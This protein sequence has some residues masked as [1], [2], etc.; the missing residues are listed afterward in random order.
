MEVQFPLVT[1]ENFLEYGRKMAR[2]IAR[3]INREVNHEPVNLVELMTV[4]N[5]RNMFLLQLPFDA[6][7]I[8]LG[9]WGYLVAFVLISSMPDHR[10]CT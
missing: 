9:E 10:T 5:T 7:C 4:V 8:P 6:A 1:K 2:A 3:R